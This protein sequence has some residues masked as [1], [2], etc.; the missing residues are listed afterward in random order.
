[1]SRV[2]GFPGCCAAV[3]LHDLSWSTDKNE[4]QYVAVELDDKLKY[5]KNSQMI[6]AIIHD[7]KQPI[8]K[9]LLLKRG[10]KVVERCK[11]NHQG[12]ENGQ[13]KLSLMV[14]SS[15]PMLRK[16]VAKKGKINAS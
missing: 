13:Y 8:V 1:M 3:I 12:G 10:F 14:R 15:E 11:G 9:E 4:E 7:C 2:S 16:P 5:Y 6:A